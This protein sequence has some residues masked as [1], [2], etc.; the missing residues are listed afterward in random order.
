MLSR[1]LPPSTATRAMLALLLSLMAAP[2]QAKD[3]DFQ[4]T[5]WPVV[6]A[7]LE[8]AEVKSSDVVYDLGAGD[9]RIVIMAARDFG[10]R[11]V[12]IDIDPALVAEASV[13]AQIAGVGDKVKFIEGNMYDADVRP[14]T[15]VTLFLHPEPNRR[16]KPKLLAQLAPG[17]RVV[18]YVWDMDDWAPA[19]TRRVGNRT[20]YLWRIP[21]RPAD[22][23]AT[24][25]GSNHR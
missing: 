23:D 8:L 12:G 3:V 25:P 18:S 20:I 22:A 21:A 24:A 13:N 2:A 19:A 10:A 14:A 6:R 7:M 9:G 15:V 11:G 17:S 5:P 1:P 4:P 16:L